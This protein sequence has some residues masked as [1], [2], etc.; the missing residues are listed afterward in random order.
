M[1]R[2]FNLF[3]AV[4]MIFSFTCIQV[5]AANGTGG[6]GNIDGGGGSMGDATSHGSWNPGNE[7]VR[8]TVVRASDHAVVTTPFDL[9][10]KTPSAGIYHFGKV[11]KIQYNNGTGL[12]P[13]QGGYSYKNPVQPMPR[14][15]STNGRNNIEAIKKYFCSEYVVKFIAEETGMDYDTLISGE[16][17]ILLE[18]IAYY[19][20]QGVMIATTATEA[21][22]YD[23]VV[24]GQLRYWM[25]SLT[26]KNL[27]LSMFLE[28]PDLGYPA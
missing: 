27:P 13:V 21:A 11:S 5:Y 2:L 28:T 22:L 25:G 6:S 17:K 4:V 1:K 24:G 26:A 8:V 14:I 15:I 19:K 12:S 7:G 20:F 18:P 16:Y 9:T 23:E 3:L 10:N